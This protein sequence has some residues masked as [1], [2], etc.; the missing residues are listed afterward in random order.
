A[1]RRA[2]VVEAGPGR[3]G[4]SGNSGDSGTAFDEA[5]HV[6]EDVDL[7]WR[8]HEAGWR[9][10]Y[11]PAAVVEHEHRV[12]LRRWLG[13]KAFYGEGAAP[14]AERH[15]GA[16]APMILAPWS[17]AAGVGVLSGTRVGLGVAAV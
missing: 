9:L 1:V 5:M 15:R 6:A 12:E 4:D 7:C 10:R 8:L 17:A 11:E 14:L 13:R 3:A 2:A 16:V